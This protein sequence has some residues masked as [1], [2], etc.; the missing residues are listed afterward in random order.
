MSDK[1]S[2]G[3]RSMTQF[4]NDQSK[5]LKEKMEKIGVNKNEYSLSKIVEKLRGT[6][7]WINVIAFS[8]K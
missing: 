4:E 2:Q 6:D 1:L 7:D 8:K 3:K 5:T